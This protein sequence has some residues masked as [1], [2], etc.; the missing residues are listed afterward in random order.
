MPRF[1]YVVVV[2]L[3]GWG[4]MGEGAVR[5]QA[6]IDLRV[7][8]APLTA[9]LE[10]VRVQT[11]L[12]L[13]YAERLVQGR[14][15]SC[16]YTGDDGDAALMC[17]LE[18][19]GVQAERVRRGQY[20][21]VSKSNQEIGA[22][23]PPRTSLKGYVLDA[24][25]GERLP[26]AHVYLTQLKAGATTNQDGYFVLSGLP[27]EDYAVRISY[28]GYRSADT[29]L[30]AGA[31][32]VRISLAATSIQSEGVVV[33]AGSTRL[34]DSE[35]RPGMSSVA[36]NRLDQLPSFG[37]PDLFRALQWTPGIRKSGGA[38][39]GLSVRGGNPDQNLYLLDGAPVYHPWHAFS[40]ISTFQTQTLRST[41]LYRG[42]FPAKHGGRLSA[43]LDAQ[44]KDGSRRAPKAVVGLSVLSGRFRIESPLTNS[45]SFMVSG[46]RSYLDKLVGRQHP[47]T[48]EDGRRDTLRTGYYFF[49]TS[50]K[51]THRFGPNHRFSLS[52]YHG[53]D[54]LDLRLPFDLSLDFSS[55]LR[56]AD[57]LFEVSQNWDNRVVSGQ[58]RYLVG[59]D[60]FVTTTGYY[61]GYR[62]QEA[63][64]VQP[65]T[66]A[67]LTSDYR[68]QLSDA[69]V[70]VQADYHHS[71]S[72]E[73]TGGL[74]VSSLQFES[75][76]ESDLQRSSRTAT[77][78][79]QESRVSAAKVVGY[80]Q[81]TWTP[82]PR[83]T[84]ESGVRASYFSGGNYVHAAPRL[85]VQHVVHPRWLVVEGSGGL[86]VQYLQRLRDR[87]S[88]AYDLVSSR[89]VPASDRVRPA[90]GGQVGLGTYTQLRPGWTLE[91]DAYAREN[92]HTLVPTDA[93]Q[94]KE[95]IDGP[96][97]EIGALLGQYVTGAERA[98]GLELSTLYE[99]GSWRGRLVVSTGRTIVRAP[100]RSGLR[101]RPSGLDVPV[102]VRST[103]GWEGE[104]W[105]ATAAAELR[106][107][108]PVTTPEARYQL[109]DP[110]ATR[111]TTYLHRPQ[112]HNGRL[113]P[114]FR[115]DLT[116]G[117]QF[118]VLSAN[119]TATVDV[120]NV[121]NRDNILDQTYRPT[122]TGVNI[123][124]QR[125]LPILP[126]VELE[127]DL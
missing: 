44:M 82:T 73:L 104:H 25:T 119:W 105:Q 118:R 117:Y 71:V 58:H 79:V 70:R 87:Y 127:M 121:I 85:S 9:V 42:T 95:G 6:P 76:L 78:R 106:S 96:G 7:T 125:G 45:T 21:L 28:L 111:S 100:A 23:A 124:R 103:L 31:G 27:P 67:S 35:R 60:V 24:E 36:L 26:G 17:A 40:L 94:E 65:T 68:V 84:V 3:V 126:L 123:N 30:T 20:V 93:L 38:S 81:D 72:H 83:W 80:L 47:V 75:T 43:V 101:W 13:V 12:E 77:Q 74:E 91:V 66:T 8:E 59:D 99:H 61:S 107:G 114:Y 19:T 39:G 46:R 50:A 34:D 15:T 86:H 55:W 88:L 2:A 10:E 54:D 108:Y 14:T 33:E 109:G 97:I 53:R 116:V 115:V 16:S 37:E 112:V 5:A 11:N 113:P 98:V 32:P 63:S 92:R 64:F 1:L 41:D 56:P 49:D 51:L 102:S 48:G 52:Y 62:A 120:F 18:G 22:E 90:I 57:L 110:T 69:G 4:G 89:W 29:T 122:E